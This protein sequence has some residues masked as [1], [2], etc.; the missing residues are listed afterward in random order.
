MRVYLGGDAM[1]F[2]H[3]MDD[4]KNLSNCHTDNKRTDLAHRRKELVGG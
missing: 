1:L 3:L 2:V 4:V